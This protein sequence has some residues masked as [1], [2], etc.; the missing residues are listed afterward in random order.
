[1]SNKRSNAVLNAN[2]GLHSARALDT[3]LAIYLGHDL[4]Q[5]VMYHL[6]FTGSQSIKTYQATTKALARRLR[7]YGCRI[8]YFGAYEVQPDKGLHAHVFLLIETSKKTP[9]KILDITEGGYLAKLAK[10]KNINPVHISKPKHRMHG[11]QL[12]ARPVGDKL[13]DCKAWFS[14]IY[15]AR[16][17]AGVPSR[18][19]YFNSEFAANKVIRD[20]EMQQW[21]TPAPGKSKPVQVKVTKGSSKNW[22]G[23]TNPQSVYGHEARMR[24]YWV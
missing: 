14:Y 19:T 4:K 24:I 2:G 1:M 5:P 13:E 11:G 7:N 9:F 10:T 3:A 22:F 18:E 21:L 12:F 20:A 6:V 15:K 8:E 23:T 16:S 17:K